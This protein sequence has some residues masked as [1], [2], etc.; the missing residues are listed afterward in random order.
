MAGRRRRLDN[1][2]VTVPLLG[3]ARDRRPLIVQSDKTLLLEVDHERADEA[4]QAI[5]PF[6]DELERAPE[7]VHTYRSPRSRCGMRAPPGTTP[8]RSSTRSSTSPV[9]G[10][11]AAA[12]RHRRH[13]GPL[14]TAAVGEE[15]G[16]R[17][18]SGE[19]GPC[20]AHE[21]MRHKKIAPMLGA[22]IDD[23]TVIVHPSERGHLKQMLPQDRLAGRGPRRV[24]RR[25]GPPH[26]PRVEEGPLA[27]ARLPGV[28]PTRSGP[29]AP[30]S[31][32]CPVAPARRW[33][34]PPRW[35]K[36]K[37]TS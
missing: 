25:R 23:D 36:A 8:S 19:P 3:G 9:R 21:V 35:P 33:W 4:R 11:A 26:R 12:G 14:R 37:A 24:R 18:H 30:A 15:P 6:A 28:A 16:A 20:G 31:W 10:A 5:A 27:V 34:A 1:G 7:H 13:H 17:S 32:C 29:A 2:L 22:K